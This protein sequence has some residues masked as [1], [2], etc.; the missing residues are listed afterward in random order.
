MTYKQL[1]SRFLLLLVVALFSFP[2][3]AQDGQEGAAAEAS[4]PAGEANID[5]G[6]TL[7]RNYCATCHNKNMKDNLTGPALGG[8]EERWADYPREDLYSWIRNSQAMVNAG[9]PRAVELWNEWKPTVMNNFNLTDQEIENIIAYVDYVYTGKDKVGQAV[10]QGPAVVVEKPNNTPLFIALAVILAI[11]AVV[12]ARIVANLNYM[13]QVREGNAPA[14][15]KTLVEILTSKG[16]IAFVIFALV[17]LGG[18]TTVNNAIMLGRQQG[19]APE[20]PIKFSHA[21]HAGLQKIDCQYC[22]DGAR[23]S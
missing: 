9:H 16:L 19:Y 5:E 6:K 23:R 22:H 3:T 17:V 4:A 18:Y 11:L 2:A 21:T 1:I 8:L 20:Q 13:V 7:F 12:L 14:H 10:A 15:R